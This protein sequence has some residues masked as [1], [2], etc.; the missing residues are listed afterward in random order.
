[1]SL[2]SNIGNFHS[3][4]FMITINLHDT[5]SYTRVFIRHIMHYIYTNIG[6][7]SKICQTKKPIVIPKFKN[8]I[9]FEIYIQLH[10]TLSLSKNII[11]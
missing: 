11:L 9:C 1:M 2:S 6:K 8:S 3:L 10:I 7:F 4:L 5:L